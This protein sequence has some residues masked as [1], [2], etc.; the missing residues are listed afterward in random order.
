MKVVGLDL[1]LTATG[2]S[3]GITYADVLEPKRMG[4]ARLCWLTDAIKEYCEGV[5]VAA[6][7]GPSYNS[8]GGQSHERAGLWWMVAH[9][10]AINGI[11]YLVMPPTSL[12]KYAT[13]TGG[14]SKDQVLATVV[15]RYPHLPVDNNN[16]AD[17]V[18]LADVAFALAGAPIAVVPELNRASLKSV[19]RTEPMAVA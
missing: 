1:S 14:A 17:A 13:G 15:R 7:E 19:K 3:D 2:V 8:K 10:L 11:P 5:D 12:K 6:I 16:A 4:H 18:V 9:H